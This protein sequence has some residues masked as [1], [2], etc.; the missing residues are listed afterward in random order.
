MISS[1]HLHFDFVIATSIN[2]FLSIFIDNNDNN[3]QDNDDNGNDNNNDNDD[4][5]D[6]NDNNINNNNNNVLGIWTQA[7]LTT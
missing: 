4:N 3:I 5:N 7:P 2:G 6:N 1:D